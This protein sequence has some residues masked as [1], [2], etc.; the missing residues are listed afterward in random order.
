MKEVDVSRA[1][2]YDKMHP[3]R[4]HGHESYFRHAKYE[5]LSGTPK[6]Q[7]TGE[8]ALLPSKKSFTFKRNKD[9]HAYLNIL[10]NDLKR[11]KE[12]HDIVHQGKAAGKFILLRS[13][14]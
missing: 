3:R 5:H 7:R 12:L 10:N 11:L 6:D 9:S 2:T 13:I 1:I 4:I 8:P 14:N